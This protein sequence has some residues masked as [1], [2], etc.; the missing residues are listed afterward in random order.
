MRTIA[1]FCCIALVTSGCAHFRVA[2]QGMPPS[3]QPQIRRVHAI[4][5]G[6]LETRTTPDNCNG[7]GMSAVTVKVTT[8]DAIATVLTLGFWTPVTV[9]WTCAKPLGV[10]RPGEKR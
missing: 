2:P 9:E 5:W 3:T 4:L 6:A 8:V 7:N 1:W 10:A